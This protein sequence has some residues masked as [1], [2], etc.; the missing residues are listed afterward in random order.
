MLLSEYLNQVQR[1]PEDTRPVCLMLTYRHFEKYN[2]ILE[3]LRTTRMDVM[4]SHRVIVTDR[5]GNTITLKDRT[6]D[7]TDYRIVERPEY[8]TY[9]L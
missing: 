3:R 5:D 6:G 4:W 9:D 8:L 1:T 7:Y 2:C